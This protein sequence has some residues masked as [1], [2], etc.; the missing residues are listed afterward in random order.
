MNCYRLAQGGREDEE[1]GRE[2]GRTK[3]EGGREDEERGRPREG[4]GI[5]FRV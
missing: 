2:G 4:L 5:G 3:R 1:R